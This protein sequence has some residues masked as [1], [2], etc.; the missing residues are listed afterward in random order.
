M[1][2]NGAGHV[3][4]LMLNLRWFDQLVGIAEVLTLGAHAGVDVGVL[5]ISGV[6]LRL[7]DGPADAE[8]EPGERAA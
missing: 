3:V 5:Q 7:P 4:K 8:A 1:G 6:L 2:G